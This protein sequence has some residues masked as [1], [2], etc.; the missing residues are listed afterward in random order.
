VAIAANTVYVVSFWAGGGR[1]GMTTGTLTSNEANGPLVALQ[2]GG[3]AG[4][5]GVYGVG[6]AFPSRAEPGVNFW[7]DVAFTP[8]SSGPAAGR[9]GEVSGPTAGRSLA[10]SF[11]IVMPPDAPAKRPTSLVGMWGNAGD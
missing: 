8:S 6:K 4:A 1:F 3:A 5:N 9:A 10:S 7:V 2:N 11:V